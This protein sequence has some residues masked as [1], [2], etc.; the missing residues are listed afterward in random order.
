MKRKIT[1]LA[2]IATL[3]ALCVPAQAQQAKVYRIG[4]PIPSDTW[5]ETIDGLR[6]GLKELGLEEGKQFTLAIRDWKGDAK[7]AEEAARQCKTL[8]SDHGGRHVL[9]EMRLHNRGVRT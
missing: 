5:Y 1:V 2:L 3:F 8:L 9:P 4:V 6:V 7:A